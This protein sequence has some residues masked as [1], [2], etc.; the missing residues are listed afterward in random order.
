M[1]EPRNAMFTGM[2]VPLCMVPYSDDQKYLHRSNVAK[3]TL[4]STIILDNKM[5][6]DLPTRITKAKDSK[7]VVMVA[8]R[9]NQLIGLLQKIRNEYGDTPVL[10]EAIGRSTDRILNIFFDA[11]MKE[12]FPPGYDGAHMT[13]VVVEELV[14]AAMGIDL[15]FGRKVKILLHKINQHFITEEDSWMDDVIRKLAEEFKACEIQRKLELPVKGILLPN[16]EKIFGKQKY[17]NN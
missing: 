13:H 9:F 14:T 2:F 5:Y 10:K 17:D 8:P 11:H 12:R 4:F 16:M 7:E 6:D 1:I 15:D 3:N